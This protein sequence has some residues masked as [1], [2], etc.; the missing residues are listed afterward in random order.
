MQLRQT[1]WQFGSYHITDMLTGAES[2]GH[3]HLHWEPSDPHGAL[4]AL[5]D[6]G[7]PSQ[8]QTRW[9]E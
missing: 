3:K 7:G 9:T 5:V 6:V 1:A 2:Y 4:W 8:P